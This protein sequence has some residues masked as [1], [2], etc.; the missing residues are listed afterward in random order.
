M[1]KASTSNP[2]FDLKTHVRDAKGNIVQ[3]NHYELTIKNHVMEFERPPKSGNFYDG[4]GTLLRSA[5]KATQAKSE[6]SELDVDNL[7]KQVTELKA[8]LA[9]KDKINLDEPHLEDKEVEEV[10]TA[11]VKPAYIKK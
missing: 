11:F 3:E 5:D 10:K 4:S 8:Q 6:A 9:E 7:L 1:H 2:Q